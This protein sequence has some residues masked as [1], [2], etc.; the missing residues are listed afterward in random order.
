MYH[1]CQR[2]QRARGAALAVRAVAQD[3]RLLVQLLA[4][5]E[6]VMTSAYNGRISAAN[7]TD[8]RNFRIVWPGSLYAIDYWV[9]LTDSP[10]V[11]EAH[12]FIRFAS[13][14][15]RQAQLPPQV[16][17]GVTHVAAADSI[18]AD[19]LPDVPTAP[20]NLEAAFELDTE[21]WVRLSGGRAQVIAHVNTAGV[22]RLR[23]RVEGRTP[24]HPA[25]L[26]LTELVAAAF[27]ERGIELRDL[28]RADASGIDST[29]AQRLL[30]WKPR[31]SWRDVL[32]SQ[33]RGR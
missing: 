22:A 14:P 33:G 27:P 23:N 18:P 1:W 17:Y 20:E 28:P 9:I 29:K 16:P 32:D 11:D 4:A 24:S 6:V 12:E 13:D 10:Y 5:G 15:E 19:V 25:V 3:A 26:P 31:R 30:D 8:G 21:F 7:K 2:H